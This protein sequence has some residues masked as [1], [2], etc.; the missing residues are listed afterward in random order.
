VT[1]VVVGVDGSESS[2]TAARAAAALAEATGATLHVVVAF[3]RLVTGEVAIDNEQVFTSSLDSARRLAAEVAEEVA[4]DGATSVAAL[5]GKPHEVL[6][7]EA[8]RLD[9]SVIVVGNRRM[10]GPGRLLGSVA[11]SV[12]HHAPCDVYIVKTV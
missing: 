11:S 1:T 2:R 8:R 5:V 4:P 3:D 10:Q 7:A 9:A 12:A 6:L